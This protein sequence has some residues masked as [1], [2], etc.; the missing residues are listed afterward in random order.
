MKT[1]THN[2]GPVDWE[3]IEP[4]FRAG[5]RSYRSIAAEFDVTPAAILKHFKKR[6]ITRDLK[7]RILAKAQEEVNAAAVNALV[8][9]AAEPAIIAA[10]ASLVAGVH[11]AHRAGSTE[12]RELV[13]A[14]LAEARA[15]IHAPEVFAQ[16]YDVLANGEDAEHGKLRELAELVTSLPA[17]A[18]VMKDLLECLTR[19]VTI[20]RLA[21]GMDDKQKSAEDADSFETLRDLAS[22]TP[23]PT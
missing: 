3:A 22:Q 14:L 12:A 8:N 23:A 16:V 10:N 9:K 6:G 15:A 2:T 20:E 5:I 18:K 17:R 4:H 21:Y 7:A 11:L 13:A 19:V 1:D